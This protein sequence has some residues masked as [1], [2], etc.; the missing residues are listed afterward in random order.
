MNRK[1]FRLLSLNLGL[2]LRHGARS[3]LVWSKRN[4]RAVQPDVASGGGCSTGEYVHAFLR[5]D[6]VCG[7]RPQSTD[8][9]FL[10]NLWQR[11]VYL[12][13][14]VFPRF[15]SI[16]SMEMKDEQNLH[17]QKHF[18]N[19]SIPSSLKLW[20]VKLDRP[21][22]FR[23]AIRSRV[24]I[25]ITLRPLLLLREHRAVNGRRG[26]SRAGQTRSDIPWG[27]TTVVSSS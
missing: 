24:E 19:R 23:F 13:H 25:L 1:L 15:T 21:A 6:S 7:P 22:Q 3:G 2:K 10:I 5:P 16:R 9:W 4:V 20:T 12:V 26:L 14:K 17:R 8:S 18:G 11:A 27:Q